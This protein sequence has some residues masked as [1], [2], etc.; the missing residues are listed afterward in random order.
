MQQSSADRRLNFKVAEDLCIKNK[1]DPNKANPAYGYL[2]SE[3]VLIDG[4]TTYN[5]PILDNQVYNTIPQNPTEKRLALQDN[6]VV[7]SK[8]FGIY[9]W[10]NSNKRPAS[11]LITG[12]TPYNVPAGNI[13]GTSATTQVYTSNTNNLMNQNMNQ[14]WQSGTMSYTMDYDVI[15]PRWDCYQ[16]YWI[17]RT[18]SY[19]NGIGVDPADS[20]TFAWDLA[21]CDGL[22]SGWVPMEP[23][24]ILSGG[25]N[26][27]INYNLP[28]ALSFANMGWDA[29][30]FGTGALQAR[31]VCIWRGILLQNTTNVK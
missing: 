8:F 26:T 29:T 15:I 16:H 22:D 17:P 3:T 21:Q 7:G 5:F 27:I 1:I 6:F 28:F 24:I 12:F 14:W 4:T 2:R 25:K 11:N 31:L 20:T 18:Q 13:L 23:N 30:G 19:Y 10:D 9:F